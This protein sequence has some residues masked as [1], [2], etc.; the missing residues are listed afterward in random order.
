MPTKLTVFQPF[1]VSTNLPYSIKRGEVVTIPI[2][3]FNYLD[4]DQASE[5]TFYNSEGE[6]EFVEVK[7]DDNK[8]RKKRAPETERKKLVLAK[9]QTGTTVPFMIRPLKI[10]HITIKVVASSAIAGDGVERQLIVEPE[11]VTQFKNKAVFIDL[12]KTPEFKTKIDITIPSYAVPDSTKIEASAVGDILGS[13][14]ANLDQL[15]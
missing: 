3:L 11:G 6:F 8:V 15:M 7:E 13:S 1:F 5:V 14:I 2:I 4:E 9:S 10:G 12:R